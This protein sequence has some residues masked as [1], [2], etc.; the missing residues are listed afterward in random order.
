MS[1]PPAVAPLAEAG[2]IA[3]IRASSP[4]GAVRAVDALVAGGITGIEITY[5]T[6]DVPRALTAVRERHGDDV[7]LGAGTV[8]SA[9]QAHE[10]A[11][12]GADFLV[13]PGIDDDVA[14]AMV[15]TGA[16]VMLGALTPTEV[17][18]ALRLG[19]HAVKIFPGSMGGPSYLRALRG[20]FPTLA[21][22]PTGG[23]SAD[24]LGEWLRSGAFAVGAGGE[25]ASAADIDAG[26]W[27]AIEANAQ[28]FRAALTEARSAAVS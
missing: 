24:N 9:A 15:A 20:P 21:A 1:V 6:P 12:A 22:M 11:R 4:D 7:A 10:A 25:L 2:V 8:L 18:R 28:R 14:A 26:R 16:T 5:S 3:V 19:A 17:L 23:V 27:E 13:S